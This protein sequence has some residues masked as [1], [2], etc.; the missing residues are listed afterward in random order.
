MAAMGMPCSVTDVCD[1]T[2]VNRACSVNTEPSMHD[3]CLLVLLPSRWPDILVYNFLHPSS[4]AY[5][6]SGSLGLTLQADIPI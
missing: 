1:G 5:F 2:A 6:T 4:I 3:P